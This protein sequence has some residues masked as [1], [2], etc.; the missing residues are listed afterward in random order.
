MYNAYDNIRNMDYLVQR[1]ADIRLRRQTMARMFGYT[2]R[3]DAVE[4]L[5]VA[6]QIR[7]IRRSRS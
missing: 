4:L 7:R 3:H 1:Q 5:Q 6:A 2:T